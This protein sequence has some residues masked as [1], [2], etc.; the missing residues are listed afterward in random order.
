VRVAGRVSGAAETLCTAPQRA[1]RVMSSGDLSRVVALTCKAF[2]PQ[3]KGHYARAVEKGAA[4]IAA[5]QELAQEDYCLVVTNL[6]LMHLDTLYG[7]AKTPGLDPEAATAARG[8]SFRILLA[9]FASLERRRAAGTLLPGTCRGWPEEEW[10]EQFIRQRQVLN[11]EPAFEQEELALQVQ[12]VG[13]DAY[14][15]AA[16]DAVRALMLNLSSASLTFLLLGRF[17]VS[18]L[19]LF[20][21]PRPEFWGNAPLSSENVLANY[22]QSLTEQCGPLLEEDGPGVLGPPAAE[23]LARWQRFVRSGVLHDRSVDAGAERI[24]SMSAATSAA[25]AARLAAATL[26]C[27]SLG[28][29]GA[30]ELHPGHYKQC[31]ACKA[32]AYC[33]REHQLE[34][35]PAHKAACK[36]ARK[37]AAAEGGRAA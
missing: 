2:E 16:S 20:E 35:W 14:L 24:R 25:I 21:Q 12:F 29:C 6:G 1:Q 27:C 30:R 19:D 23:L 13:Y 22:M 37:A 36:A 7:Y 4:A 33:C 3:E 8:E 28:S 5:A 18:A 32:V 34:D 11:K 31:G 17:A 15:F 10:Y 26:R 9:A